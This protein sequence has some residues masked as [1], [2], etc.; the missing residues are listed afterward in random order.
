[1][2]DRLATFDRA[3]RPIQRHM[4][5]LYL[6]GGIVFLI[7]AG[8]IFLFAMYR[9]SMGLLAINWTEIAALVAAM[10]G[11]AASVHSIV[12]NLNNARNAERIEEI[13]AGNAPPPLAVPSSAPSAPPAEPSPTGGLVNNDALGGPP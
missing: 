12:S 9:W 3:A 11:A 7:F 4:G 13:R 8:G 10:G 6:L 2:S 5:W 1:M